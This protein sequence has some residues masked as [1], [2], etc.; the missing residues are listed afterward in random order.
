MKL[1]YK[2][3]AKRA[4]AGLLTAAMLCGQAG[5]SFPAY[6]APAQ[7]ETDETMYVNLDYYGK[8]TRVNVVKGVSLNGQTEITDYGT[9]TGVE[10]MSNDAAPILGE[11]S[12][13]WQLPEQERGRFYYKCSLDTSQVV[14]PWKLDVSY[15]LNGVPTDGDKLA[16][17]SGLVEIHVKAEPEESAPLYYRN[18]MLLTVAVPVDLSECYSVEAEGSQT[19]NLGDTTAVVFAALPG[20]EGDYTVRIGTDSFESIGVIMMMMPGTVEDLEHVKDL[21]E[22]KDTWQDAG[23]QLYDSM[24]QMARSVESMRE[25]I[26]QLQSGTASADA[27][28]QKWSDSRDSIL[29]G[30]DQ[31]LEALTALTR[32]METMVPHLQTAKEEARIIHDSM[33]NIVDVLADMQDPLQRLYSRL[34]GIE[35]GAEALSD[36]IPGLEQDAEA[37]LAMDT[38]LQAGNVAVLGAL[39]QLSGL[40]GDIED[41]YG[42]GYPDGEISGG[43]DEAGEAAQRATSS[44]ATREEKSAPRVSAGAGAGSQELMAVLEEKAARLALVAEK[45]Q[46]MARTLSNMMDDFADAAQY[47]GELTDEMVFLIEDVKALNDSLDMYYPDLQS[48]L[49]DS[50]ELVNRTTEALDSGIGTMTILQNT[51]KDSSGD[52][53]AAARE[54]LRGTMEL[55]DRSLS[56]LDSTASMRQAGRTMKDVVDEQLDQFD[57]ENRFLFMDPSAEKESFTSEK[58]QAPRTLQIVLRTDEISLGDEEHK[59]AD[60]ETAEEPVSPLRR[61]WNVLVQMWQAI[62]TIFKNR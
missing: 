5:G 24:E 19:Q 44:S 38:Q 39:E 23:D 28:R 10:N 49:D 57:T 37:I 2:T 14:L 18:N 51:L 9:Y 36:A 30:N 47:T 61:M 3:R 53:D 31:T 52:L 16:G 25:G 1:R 4:A 43:A 20:E 13:T 11:D 59:S 22:A 6:G 60:A 45:S 56:V 50:I 7:A 27:A 42:E 33:N 58:N 55:L 54:S 62:V 34:G 15:K 8:T 12:V 17:A 21:K 40:I 35:S 26:G 32:Q 41:L 48:A 46:K 29:A